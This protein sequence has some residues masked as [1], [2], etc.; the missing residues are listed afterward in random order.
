METSSARKWD[1]INDPLDALTGAPAPDHPP[2]VNLVPPATPDPVTPEL[3]AMFLSYYGLRTN[4]FADS[5][6]PGFFYRTEAH[7]DALERMILTIEN[8][9]SLGMVTGESGTGKTLLTQL[10]LQ[11]LDPARYCPV[12][13]LVSPGLSKTGL[14]REI[15]S[16]LNVALPVGVARTQELIKLLGNVVI[17][18]HQQGRKLVILIDECH[19]LSGDNLHILRTISNIEIPER[20]LVTCLLFGEA[21]FP[22]RLQH[23]SFDSIRNRMYLQCVLPAMSP[24][25]CAEYVKF[26]LMSSGGRDD[27]FDAEALAAIHTRA[28]GIGRSVNKLC[29]LT[30]LEGCMARAA[31]ISADLVHRA[32]ARA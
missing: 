5:L 31:S 1:A 9:L 19:F 26:R 18:L 16:E 17:E 28:G 15:L 2:L 6:N 32:A 29:M 12:L 10:I 23:P 21:R 24:D 14:L 22:Q 13:V 27:L 3:G 8:D 11:Q 4:P 20:K 30:L 7:G 25:D